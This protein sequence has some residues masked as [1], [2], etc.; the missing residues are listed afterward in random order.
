MTACA[1]GSGCDQ[2]AAVA[3]HTAGRDSVRGLN[4]TLYYEPENAPRG[5]ERLC[6]EHALDL[7]RGLMEVLT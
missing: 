1:S 5:C 6:A 3:V 2:P 7:L 4:A